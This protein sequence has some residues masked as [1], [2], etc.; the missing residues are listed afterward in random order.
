MLKMSAL[1]RNMEIGLWCRL[2]P[3]F[4]VRKLCGAILKN[5]NCVS[6]WARCIFHYAA[7]ECLVLYKLSEGA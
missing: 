6:N 1:L 3:Q 7:G 2:L 4:E 5:T